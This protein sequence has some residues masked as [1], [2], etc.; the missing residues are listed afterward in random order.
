MRPPPPSRDTRIDILDISYEKYV[1]MYDAFKQ[2]RKEES[3]KQSGGG[4][5]LMDE[6]EYVVMVQQHSMM[7]GQVF[8]AEIA[9][10]YYRQI[11]PTLLAQQQTS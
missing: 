2:A 6:D 4:V 11:K 1:E 10:Q 8:N 5:R 7:T 9:R 3:E